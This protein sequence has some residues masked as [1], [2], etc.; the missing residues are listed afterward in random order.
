MRARD[1]F[2]GGFKMM[3]TYQKTA[4]MII[5]PLFLLNMLTQ[6][7]SNKMTMGAMEQALANPES[8]NPMAMMGPV[9]LTMLI[10]IFIG[11]VV[12]VAWHRR[13]L[14]DEAFTWS[15]SQ[16]FRGPVF[17]YILWIIVLMLIILLVSL[18]IGFVGGMVIALLVAISPALAAIVGIPAYI[19]FILFLVVYMTRISV[20][21]PAR[22]VE[23][24]I[25]IKE[26]LAAT[27]GQGW[28]IIRYTLL[29]FVVFMIVLI[30]LMLPSIMA[31]TNMM[32]GVVTDPAEIMAASQPS[33]ISL[34]LISAF[35]AVVGLYQ[36]GIM[37]I[38]YSTF[39][40]TKEIA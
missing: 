15:P 7:M 17:S 39:V 24:P 6:Y 35:S 32:N 22:A 28:M 19:A 30:P 5:V 25:T 20:I 27:K 8:F 3:K 4:L 37:T 21:L 18:A 14:L 38:L 11:A 1:L 36:I 16:I 10:S 23:R 33:M 40:G 31:Q 29:T 26:A 13:A 12:A 34:I 2:I 9:L